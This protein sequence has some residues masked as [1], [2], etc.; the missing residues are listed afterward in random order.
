MELKKDI[1]KIDSMN[2]SANDQPRDIVG[3]IVRKTLTMLEN[4]YSEDK[5][6]DKR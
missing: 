2:I 5:L 4:K 6:Q 1:N 3:E